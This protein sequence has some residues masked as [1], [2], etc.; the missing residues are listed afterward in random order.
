MKIKRFVS[1]RKH[2]SF[3]DFEWA[4]FCRFIDGKDDAG[5]PKVQIEQ[6]GAV[7]AIFGENGS[8]KSTL[9]GILKSLSQYD[10]FGT[11]APEHAEVEVEK[12]G[13][14]TVH[15]FENGTW[16]NSRLDRGDIL[17]F[18]VD[19]ISG[20]VHTHG[21][22][23]NQQGQHSQNAGQLIIDLDTEAHSL[24]AM[25]ERCDGE[26]T[27]FKKINDRALKLEASDTDKAY[28]A[29]FVVMDAASNAAALE[30]A[31]KASAEAN[32]KLGTLRKLEK[33]QAEIAGIAVVAALPT[34]EAILGLDACKELFAREVKEKAQEGADMHVQA[35]FEKH[36]SFIEFAKGSIPADYSSH[37]CPLC[38]QPLANATK[39][40][41]YYKAA[42]DQTYESEK[43]K[44]LTDVES[45][46]TSLVAL[47]EARSRLSMLTTAA[48]ASLEK[49]GT[50]FDIEGLYSVDEK[51]VILEK[52]DALAVPDQLLT[53]M[54]GLESLKML[55]RKPVDVDSAH[56][57]LVTYSG[58]IADMTTETNDMIAQKN[59][60]ITAFKAK[61]VDKSTFSSE[62]STLSAQVA[63]GNGIA[64]F[65]ETGKLVAMKECDEALT[66][67]K[68]LTDAMKEATD[69]LAEHLANKIP[70]SVITKMAAI[71]DRFSL[72]FVLE[73]VEP[74]LNTKSYAFSYLV[75][76]RD[77][78]ER[79]FKDGLSEGERQ[80]ISL[81]FFFAIND[82]IAGK[83]SKVLV[84]DDPITSLDAPNLKILAELIY[85]Q[86]DL[87]A[88]VIV[89]THHPL[90]FKYLSKEENVAKFGVLKNGDRFGGSF[91]YLDR[92]FNLT[93]EVKKCSEE[94]AV[95]AA[96][97]TFSP[98]QTALKYGQL[99]RIA[100]ERFIKNEVLMWDKERNFE[101]VL[102]ELSPSKAKLGKLTD[103]DL[104]TVTNLYKFCNWSNTMHVDKE[105][106]AALAE[107][108]THIEKF[109][110]IAEKVRH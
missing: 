55:V 88:Q 27:D 8:G 105:A 28:F 62:I 75:K 38:M 43:R 14:E 56:A 70:A 84:L 91:V 31:K 99:L 77:G 67:L 13:T 36:R 51:T 74:A 48:F 96:A 52:V 11:A 35:H 106:P 64:A 39:V 47:S 86:K 3:V 15:K 22:R 40:I 101:Q 73:H 25:K 79:E 59:A 83:E 10:E 32:T 2:K 44:L 9:C 78:K 33:K 104:V 12:N 7:S 23:G 53:L 21:S 80:V 61:Y 24:K 34:L 69:K 42:F 100:V 68:V 71:L 66:K 109:V 72:N 93:E 108:R 18:D 63:S 82:G 60:A 94:I 98:E 37:N 92:S 107:L 5:V 16:A 102:G 26:V 89:L 50:A 17:F 110:V 97:G 57:T 87:F 103:E 19:F 81:A 85:S 1:V 95:T 4:K 45:M 76:D 30:E 65:L 46:K 20:N 6:L 58:K 29:R 49:I 41:E 90:F 54:D